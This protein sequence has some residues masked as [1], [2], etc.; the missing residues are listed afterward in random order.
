MIRPRSHLQGLNRLSRLSKKKV[1][2][3]EFIILTPRRTSVSRSRTKF[4]EEPN[5]GGII[6]FH[7]VRLKSDRNSG[8]IVARVVAAPLTLN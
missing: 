1:F 2:R 4:P 3:G 6:N 7:P 5:F 8:E